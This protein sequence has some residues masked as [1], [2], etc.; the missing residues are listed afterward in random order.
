M[1]AS[2]PHG[3]RV[4]LTHYLLGLLPEEPIASGAK[5]EEIRPAVIVVVGG[6]SGDR[7]ANRRW[8]EAGRV[9]GAIS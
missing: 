6:N 7:S 1:P 3:A 5:D 8:N 9:P 4:D 2:L